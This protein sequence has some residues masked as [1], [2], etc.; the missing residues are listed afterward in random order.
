MMKTFS[1]VLL[2]LAATCVSSQVTAAPK[3][4]KQKDKDKDSTQQ[5]DAAPPAIQPASEPTEA[6]TSPTGGLSSLA[7]GKAPS[8]VDAPTPAPSK[9]D[10][11]TSALNNDS[12]PTS[13]PDN[14]SCP[15]IPDLDFLLLPKIFFLKA[16]QVMKLSGIVNREM[17]GPI[18]DQIEQ[19][20]EV[21]EFFDGWSDINDQAVVAKTRDK[22]ICYAVFQATEDG[23]L[24]G[25]SM[26][27]C[28]HLLLE[29]RMPKL[30]LRCILALHHY[31]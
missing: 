27:D 18:E 10:V 11:P 15:Q 21:F 17:S 19:Q 25:E 6:P 26:R 5:V 14:A 30:P 1:L 3:E 12:G 20:S 29:N 16:Q 28:V 31:T 4:Q 23:N 7:P 22:G 8:K 24:L 13:T 2:L 9:K